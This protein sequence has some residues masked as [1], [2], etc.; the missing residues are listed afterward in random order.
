MDDLLKRYV[1][2]FGEVPPPIMTTNYDDPIYIKLMEIALYRGKALTMDEVS[3]EF[4][5][6]EYDLAE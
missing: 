4:D 6:V 3:E 2:E 1:K 5:K